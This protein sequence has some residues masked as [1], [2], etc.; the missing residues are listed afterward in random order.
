ME[1]VMTIQFEV[2]REK[3]EFISPLAEMRPIS[4]Q[5]ERRKDPLTGRVAIVSSFFNEKRSVLFPEADSALIASLAERSR[6]KCFFCPDLVENA[7]PKYLESWLP[8]GRLKKGECLLFPNLYPMSAVHAVVT[9]GEKHYREL[10][11]FPPAVLSD[12]ISCATGFISVALRNN[13]SLRYFTLN[14]NYLFPAGASVVHPHAQLMGSSDPS[15]SVAGLIKAC[16]QFK[17]KHQADY[18]SS[19]IET[20]VNRK[21]RLIYH[22]ER[23]TWIAPFAP[24]GTNEVLGILPADTNFASLDQAMIDELAVGL[25]KVL[26][27]YHAQGFSTFNWSIL[28]DAAGEPHAAFPV[29]LRM[30]CRQNVYANC[31][32]DDYF[33]QKFLGEDL[34]VTHPEK[35]A[36]AISEL[37]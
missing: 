7:A 35:L 19:L 31:R 21:E 37:F 13:P 14:S 27:Y 36:S 32:S 4:G 17:E 26:S 25:S 5:I 24:I 34:V 23:I 10:N 30:I 33:L 1:K 6:S 3:A 2:T 12:A 20:E 11:N 28:S 18:F 15:T 29:L 8:G 9:I 16:R 22:N